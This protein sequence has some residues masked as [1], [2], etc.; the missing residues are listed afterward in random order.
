MRRHRSISCGHTQS[1]IKSGRSQ[2]SDARSVPNAEDDDPF[3]K[4]AT[5]A[6]LSTHRTQVRCLSLGHLRA[7]RTASMAARSSKMKMGD[8][9]G[10]LLTMSM[11]Q[12]GRWADA[13]V[14]VSPV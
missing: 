5:A 4:A 12:L 8:S 11:N 13:I 9:P 1:D 3:T 2:K 6:W 14:L 7:R 10:T